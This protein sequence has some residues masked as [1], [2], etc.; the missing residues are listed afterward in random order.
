MSFDNSFS[1]RQAQSWPASFKFCFSTGMKGN[2]AQLSKFLEYCFLI[3][4]RDADA[5]IG[6]GYFLETWKGTTIYGDITA[7]WSEFYGVV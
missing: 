6:Y 2:I 1:N 3:F 7:I 5:C 4:G